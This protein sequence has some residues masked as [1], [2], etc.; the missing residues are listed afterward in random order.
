VS[1]SKPISSQ[2]I[3]SLIITLLILEA[4]I[5]R[6]QAQSYNFEVQTIPLKGEFINFSGKCFM[7]DSE[8]FMWLGS[9]EGLYRYYGT[10]VKVYRHIPNNENSLSNNF[11]MDLYE[12]SEG[13]IWI[14]TKDGLNRFDKY[15]ETFKC[16][17]NQAGDSSSIT[18][19]EINKIAEDREGNLWI[20]NDG[21]FNR[22]DRG[23]ETFNN[24]RILRDP[25]API[26]RPFQI[27]SLIPDKEYLWLTT[28][29]GLY[30]YT[31]PSGYLKK[32]KEAFPPFVMDVL[33]DRSERYWLKCHK[34][35]LLM[36]AR[37]LS[38]K[39]F[40]NRPG[41]SRKITD[42]VMRTMLEDGSGNIWI[43]SLEG[44]YCYNQALE[45]KYFL[46][47]GHIYPRNYGITEMTKEMFLDNT[48]AIWFFSP[49]GLNQISNIKQ[50]FQIYTSDT[51]LLK[52]SR[53]FTDWTEIRTR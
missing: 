36:D 10:G 35:I 43:R 1:R 5:H 7:Q 42:Q 13:V 9:A 51:T 22:F 34:G 25:D 47:H 52:P 49:E 46:E 29:D 33:I 39:P 11:I 48:G 21:G 24:Y 18:W 4:F 15:T 32:I 8:G 16:Y 12:D 41:N 19:G 31:V 44:I 3:V 50:N 40:P 27:F 2:G 28:G 30:R 38:Y 26:K 20:A 14:G 45:L 17:R 23:T 6:G 37:E 53:A